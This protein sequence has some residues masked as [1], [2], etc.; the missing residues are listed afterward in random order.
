M[1]LDPKNTNFSTFISCADCMR[2]VCMR[3]FSTRNSTGKELLAPIPPTLAAASTIRSGFMSRTKFLVA[4]KSNNFTADATTIIG[5]L[6]K[7]YTDGMAYCSLVSRACMSL[8]YEGEKKEGEKVKEEKK[9][10][11]EKKK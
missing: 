2:L 4:S 7:N 1:Q 11:G 5:V 10:E 6:N 9:N 3:I 8:L